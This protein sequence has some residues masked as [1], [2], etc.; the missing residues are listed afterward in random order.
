MDKCK[1]V[2]R[3]RLAQDHSILNPQKWHCVDCN[4]TESVWACLSCAHVACG[5]YIEEHALRHFQDSKHPL[6]LEVNELYI[7]CYLCD[8]YVLNDNTTGDLKLLRSTL[9]AIKSQNYDCTTRSG[10]TLR[11]MVTA[12]DS[13]ISHEGAQGFLQNEDRAFTALWHRRHALLG[14][15]FRSWYDLTPKGKQRLEEE[16]LREEA[17]Q[18][19]E[20]ARKKRRQLKRMLK[21]EMESTPPRKSSRL[22]Q[23]M[24]PSPKTQLLSE[25]KTSQKT[26]PTTKHK[27]PAPTSNKK[28]GNS[29]IKRKPTVTPGV[30]GLRNLGNTCYM[31]SILQILSHLHVFRECFLRLD[32]NQTQEL[33]AAAGNGKTRSSSKHIPVTDFAK[34][35]QKHTKIQRSSTPRQSF[36]SGLSGGASNTRNME[37]IQ[38]KEP[39]SKHISL[40]HELHTLFQ[41]MWSGKWAL[42]SPFAMLHSVWRLIPAFHGYAQQDAQ[43]FLCELLDKVQQELETTSTRYPALIPGSQRKLIKQVL[44]VVNNVFH[45]QLLSQVTCLACDNKSN[46]IEPFWDLSLEFPERYHFNGK[47]SASQRPCLL[48]EM[49]AKFTETEALEGKIYACDQCN[50]AQK[51]LM[52]CQLPQVLRLHLKRFRWSGR[53]HREKIGVHVRFDQMLNMEPYCCRE[54]TATLRTNCFIYDLSAIVMHHGK[55]FG[56]GHYTAFCYNPEGGFWVHCNDSKLHT[57]TVEEVCKAQAYILF[58][59]QRVSQEIGHLSNRLYGHDSQPSTPC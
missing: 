47:E 30:T 54:S 51:Q 45:G 16:R 22:Q 59:T 32:L 57:C 4:T 41:V 1:H 48:T 44:S 11:S 27:P 10:R 46:T 25:L 24:Q 5:R 20:E 19:R 36:S 40:C 9:S 39:S 52:V 55:G 58:Y 26:V 35:I 14:K 33:L 37:L 18:K 15:V 3:L 56:S 29:P 42:V 6:A 13:F 8:E 12:D 21:E 49:L 43:E 7:F 38:P 2:G 53:N 31:N 28:S 34:V 23:Q 50:K 17:E